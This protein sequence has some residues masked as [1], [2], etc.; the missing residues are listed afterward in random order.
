MK[1]AFSPTSSIE[2]FLNECTNYERSGDY[3]PGMEGYGT[4]RMERLLAYLGSPHRLLPAIHI[5]GTKGKGSVAH[6]TARL[7]EA[8]GLHVGLYTSPHVEDFRERIMLGGE[9]IDEKTL[10]RS[11]EV[12]KP[13]VEAM[14][15]ESNPPT[16]FE[17]L[18]ALAYHAFA[19]N[20]VE[21]AVIE[22]GLGGRLD[23]TNVRDLPVVASAITTISR[24]HTQQLGDTLLAIAGEK[25]G[26]LRREVPVVLGPQTPPVMDFL[27]LRAAELECPIYRV[28]V[29]VTWTAR[30]EPPLDAPEAPQRLDFTTWRAIHHDLPLP[31]LG[32]HQ[33][34]NATIALALAEIFLQYMEM[35]PVDTATIR[36]AWR[37]VTIPGRIEVLGRSPWIIVDAAHNAASSWALSETLLQRFT[38]RRKI[39]VF[40]SSKDKEIGP[41]LR[42]LSHLA[43]VMILTS[44]TSP[45]SAKPE[46]LRRQIPPG[47]TSVQLVE[48]P[49]QAVRLALTLASEKDLICVTGSFYL[50]G[51][52][53]PEIRALTSCSS[54][55]YSTPG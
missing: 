18:T 12:V 11:W 38:A 27:L 4:A 19:E 43:D 29:D 55:F 26:I 23:A 21:A 53:R 31:L 35:G 33:A 15:R 39:F 24:D 45:R 50:A 16:Y 40:G 14:R 41:M 36:R 47:S 6:L 9:K 51:A 25:A 54:A 49:S 52:V 34:W 37:G 48:D 46:D 44:T 10:A 20:Q 17:I 32:E 30:A 22:V 8:T 3:P 7:L 5:A 2:A 42:I 28:G 13:A 1:P